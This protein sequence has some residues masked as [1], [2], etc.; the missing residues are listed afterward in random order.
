M[1]ASN[2][3]G[4]FAT[5]C[6]CVDPHS[7]AEFMKTY[8][9][10]I[11]DTSVTIS[12]FSSLREQY[13]AL[14]LQECGRREF[15][16]QVTRAR[17]ANMLLCESKFLQLAANFATILHICEQEDDIES[18]KV[19]MIL[20]FTYQCEGRFL[21][22]EL[23]SVPIWSSMR[24]WNA[25][26][27]HAVHSER[28][29]RSSHNKCFSEQTQEQRVEAAEVHKNTFFGQMSSFI[30]NMMAFQLPLSDIAEFRE[31]MFVMSELEEEQKLM[32]RQLSPVLLPDQDEFSFSDKLEN[33]KERGRSFLHSLSRSFSVE[34]A[35][36]N[37][38]DAGQT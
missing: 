27:L 38:G 26:F 21:Y 19:L 15:S 20:A 28:K 31:K 24:F 23:M 34:L 7:C 25:A 5:S 16:R 35:T 13:N 18:A 14:C 11:L 30:T 9:E 36:S 29:L 22:Q 12:P 37:N 2:G 32:L 1:T 10:A 4:R 8:V 33:L 3:N 17:S 6:T